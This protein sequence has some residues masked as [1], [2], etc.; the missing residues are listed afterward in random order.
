MQK[1]ETANQNQQT[2]RTSSMT[3]YVNTSHNYSTGNAGTT[4]I[5]RGTSKAS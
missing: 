4:E 2:V 5:I 1:I 3:R